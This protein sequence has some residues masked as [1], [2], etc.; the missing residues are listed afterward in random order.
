MGT[1]ST[2]P[3]CGSANLEP[4]ELNVPFDKAGVLF[5]PNDKRFFTLR[6]GVEVT[7]MLCMDCGSLEMHA[8]VKAVAG[9]L[10]EK[11]TAGDEPMAGEPIECFECG[12]TLDA[13]ESKCSK[14]GW[15]YTR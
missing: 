8:D 10:K 7:A 3:R 11:E 12:A 13:G 6:S 14:C 4:G 5:R 2:C 9:M 1:N 15:S